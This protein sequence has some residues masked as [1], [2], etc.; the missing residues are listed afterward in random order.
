MTILNYRN[1]YSTLK[2]QGASTEITPNLELLSKSRN[3]AFSHCPAKFL[4]KEKYFKIK[5]CPQDSLK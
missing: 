1:V 2:L 4:R 5:Y 3:Q